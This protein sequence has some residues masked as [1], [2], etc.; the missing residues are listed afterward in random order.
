M[1]RYFKIN[2]I[3]IRRYSSI[4]YDIPRSG[5]EALP[6]S[7]RP[8]CRKRH[9]RISENILEYTTLLQNKRY[10]YSWIFSYILRYIAKRVGGLNFEFQA[11]SLQATLKNIGEYLRIYNVI[12]KQMTFI[13]TDILQYS[14]IYCEAGR[15]PYAIHNTPQT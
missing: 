11:S 15:R 10:T 13:I 5:Q 7:F 9:R 3:H 14:K 8:P 1:Q 12:P 2:D 4:F 6:L